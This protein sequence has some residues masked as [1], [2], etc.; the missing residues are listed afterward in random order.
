MVVLARTKV[1]SSDRGAGQ[2]GHPP[3]QPIF[4]FVPSREAAAQV[5][6]LIESTPPP[7]S[8]N[9]PPPCTIYSFVAN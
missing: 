2:L 1:V 3:D 8:N 6:T 7:E 4:I 9:R 5:E